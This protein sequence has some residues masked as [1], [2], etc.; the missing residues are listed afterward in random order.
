MA[1]REACGTKVKT[2]DSMT[3]L[4]R[5]LN[6]EHGYSKNKEKIFKQFS[7]IVDSRWIVPSREKIKNLI[8]EGF[9]Q[10]SS[11]LRHDLLQAE[12]VLLT[13]DLLLGITATWI[14]ENF[15]LNNAILAV[16]FLRYHH[17]ADAIAK[18][19]SIT[20]N[21]EANMNS[22]CNKLGVK[23]MNCLITFF[24]A[25]KQ[26]EHLEAVQVSIQK[27]QKSNQEN[28]IK[29]ERDAIKDGKQLKSIIITDDKW[30]TVAGIIKILKP[31]N[32]ITN[33]ISGSSYSTMSIIYLTISTLCNALLRDYVD[34]D[35][36]ICD[37]D[38]IDLNTID[39]ISIF[40]LKEVSDDNE[41]IRLPAATT[42]LVERI[43][44]IMSKLFARYYQF[45]DNKILFIAMAIDPRCKNFEYED[46][47]LKCQ[48][49]LRLEYNQIRSDKGLGLSSN[50]AILDLS[51]S[52]I[53]TVF[54]AV[55]QNATRKNKVDQYLMI[56][57]I[58]PLDNP[59]Q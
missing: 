49:Y 16:T 36:D 33:Y 43:K 23:W 28:I 5:Y 14:N 7:K 20:S 45:D 24:T 35:I 59:L 53:S 30:T 17:T 11:C 41:Q 58:G 42:N 18:C 25:P 9:N 37:T 12:T 3:A 19:F 50:E 29:S 2:G 32:N 26:S 46:A 51:G 22:A 47:I 34:K 8:D 13:T 10:I 6:I 44:N 1:N 31:F 15:E 55:Q 38:E 4:W 39:D 27:Q 52:F 57:T 21:S 56:E 40:D 48:D 54:M